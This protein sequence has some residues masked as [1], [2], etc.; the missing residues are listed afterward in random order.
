MLRNKFTYIFLIYFFILY[1]FSSFSSKKYG[2]ISY[3]FA[4]SL[5]P[6]HNSKL[7]SF[8]I[9][10][11]KNG[12][13]VNKRFISESSFIRQVSGLELS[14][15]NPKKINYFEKYELSDCFYKYDSITDIYVD[16]YECFR[17]I[18][19]W[20]L[21][22]GRN[23]MC[24]QE[25]I[26]SKD[27]LV[28]GWAANKFKPSWP[29]LQILQRYGVIYIDDVFYGENM[30]NLFSDMKDSDWISNYANAGKYIN[31]NKG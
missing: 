31:R 7:V 4:F 25:C 30:F 18:D 27:M 29:Q 23:P 15:A 14:K 13:I 24:P 9:V 3:E 17:L 5:A 21:K 6:S 16:G 19:L 20:A 11:T 1:L 22:Y 12:K 2:F 10:G 8:A 28:K 26:P